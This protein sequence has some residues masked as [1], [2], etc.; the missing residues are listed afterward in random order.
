M[1]IAQELLDESQSVERNQQLG[2]QVK[3]NNDLPGQPVV[4]V[5]FFG[6]HRRFT[7][8][9]LRLL[10]PLKSLTILELHSA[11]ITD[12]GLKEIGKLT[13]LATL[14]LT[15]TEIT[16]AGLKEL[17]T[18]KNLQKLKL[19][20]N[21]QI[22]D[23]GLI[24]LKGLQALTTLDLQNSQIGDAGLNEI[25]GLKNLKICYLGSTRITDPGLSDF[26]QARPD[27]QVIR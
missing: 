12:I 1:V 4:Q 14:D 17:R 2:G 9:D 19:Y 23:A 20:V 21:H 6:S 25:K 26:Q 27:V 13:A 16:D 18:L 24:E 7:D 8:R 3:R 22:T 15:N 11:M 5:S 10:H